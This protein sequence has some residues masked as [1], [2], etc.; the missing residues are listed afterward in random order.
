MK[1][2]R[3]AAVLTT[4]F[5]AIQRK[6][7]IP[8]SDYPR[9]K[10]VR[11][12]Y[13]CLN[14]K[15][16][17]SV[18]KEGL[19]FFS[20]K[21]TVPFPPESRLSGVGREFDPKSTLVYS[22]SFLLPPLFCKERVILHFGAVDQFA[23]VFINEKKVGEHEGGYLPFSFDIT[24]ALQS[25]QNRITV[26]ARDPM[27]PDLPYGKQ[28]LNPKGM[29]YTRVSGIWQ[30][31]WL[32]SVPKRAIE[33]IQVDT[34]L[35]SATIRIS[36]GEEKKRLILCGK[37]FAEEHIFSGDQITL[38]F[39]KPALWWPEEPNLY[40]FT[41]FS[42]EDKIESYFALREISIEEKNG[43]KL[44]C[45]N[46]KPYFFHGLLDQGYFPD[47]IFLPADA[48]GY[49]FDIRK[50]KELGFNMLRKHIKLE[51]EIFYYECDRMGMAVFQDMINSSPYSF[52][53]DTAL[54]TLGIKRGIRARTSERAKK[55]F[56]ET[57]RGIQEAL[58][59]HPSVLYYTIFNE[60]WGEFDPD[61]CYLALK[62]F[63][64][65]RIY[66]ATS[67]WFFGK[68]SDV[69]SHHVYFKKLKL[70]KTD[71]PMVLSEFGGYS[72]R[73]LGH[74]FLEKGE[75]GYRFFKDEEK[76]EE[77]LF[78]LY[79]KEVLPLIEKGLCATVLTQLSDIEEE[80]N[81]IFTYD[82]KKRKGK[83]ETYLAIAKA[84]K[85][86]FGKYFS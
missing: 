8:F 47:G 58:S 22:R 19:P 15:W 17:F 49:R 5:E 3:K 84:L 74:C 23:E 31:V 21:I 36:G 82:R 79:E 4:E 28:S 24:E 69:E 10:M 70:K 27:D 41:L 72:L 37:D 81:G 61:G 64:P 30:T 55:I 63:D 53:R 13:F 33:K 34:T 42:G 38:S 60:G 57:S 59:S 14:G 32:E 86:E 18:E 9:P 54:P 52:F 7:K 51:P 20:G 1:K 39:P 83:A 80:T 85:A 56:L 71:R 45:L 78:A 26:R 76:W 25:G 6:K 48:E 75:Y 62:N 50:A 40:R 66:D 77:A 73:I 67:G 44:L 2:E 11:D 29:W 12:S 65:S 16:N 43:A 35:S 46:K 68:K